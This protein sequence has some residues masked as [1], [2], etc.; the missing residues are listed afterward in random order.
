MAGQKDFINIL[1]SIRGTG[2]PGE[3][4]T[5]GIW[6]EL[7]QADTNGNAGVY[8]DILAKYGVVVEN[9]A[10]LDQAVAIIDGLTVVANEL[11]EGLAPTAELVGTTLTLGIPVGN[12]GAAGVKGDTGLRGLTGLTGAKGDKGDTGASGADG[13]TPTDGEVDVI[14][15]ANV[16]VQ[17]AQTLLD[18]VVLE[19]EGSLTAILADR[20]SEFDANAADRLIEYDVNAADKLDTYNINDTTKMEQYNVNHIERLDEINTAYAGR[21]G[22]MMNTKRIAGMVD[23]YTAQVSIHMISFLSTDDADYIYF[24]NGVRIRETIDY[25]VYDTTTIELVN[26]ITAGDVVTQ[27]N[28]KLLK[29]ATEH[30]H[31]GMIGPTGLIPEI[32]FELVDNDVIFNIV[33]YREGTEQIEWSLG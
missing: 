25:T 10:T 33:G 20:E 23:I 13:H 16:N 31:Q 18:E 4:P 30:V 6:Y 17:A 12:T 21:I 5:D 2:V 15:S 22:D 8:G 27:I 14:V 28:T 29:E 3:A 19:A 32:E 11:A 1:Q 9:T 26:G 24:I 7:T